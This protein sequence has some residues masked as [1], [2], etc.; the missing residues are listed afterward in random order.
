[1]TPFLRIYAA[2]Q[3]LTIE[4]VDGDNYYAKTTNESILRFM[5]DS[6]PGDVLRFSSVEH[7]IRLGTYEHATWAQSG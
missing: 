3:I 1:V 6:K 7:L 5:K 2:D 4:I